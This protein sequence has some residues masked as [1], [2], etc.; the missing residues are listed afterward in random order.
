MKSTIAASAPWR[1]AAGRRAFRRR[2][3]RQVIEAFARPRRAWP[4]FAW[5]RSRRQE[6][7][8]GASPLLAGEAVGVALAGVDGERTRLGEGA[9]TGGSCRQIGRA[10]CRERG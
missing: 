1:V 9:P 2:G 10:S 5:T 7:S 6:R 3:G 8:H 4:V